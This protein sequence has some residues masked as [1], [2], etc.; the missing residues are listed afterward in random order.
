[1]ALSF[2]SVTWGQLDAELAL[3]L[4]DTNGIRWLVPERRLYLAEALREW[5]ALTQQ[6]VLDWAPTFT[7][8]NPATLPVWQSTGNGVNALAG[9]NPTSPRYQTLTNADVYTLIQYH[10]LEPPSGVGTWIGTSQ[11]SLQDFVNA[12]MRRRDQILQLTDCN[13]GPVQVS[14]IVPN[15]NR[16]QLPD[17]TSRSILDV[18]RVRYLPTSGSP[19]TLYRDDSLAMEYFD[20]QYLQTDE[21]PLTWDVLGSPQQF[22]TFDTL[23]NVPN[24]LDVLAVLSGGNLNPSDTSP[25]LIPDDFFWV[26][27]YG[28]MADLLVK[29][30]ESRD[31]LRAQY[32][33]KRFQEGIQVM[34][35]LPWL[36]QARINNIP[37]DTPS[38]YEADQFDYEWQSNSDAMAQI[39]RG[40]ID[41]FA[42]SPLIPATTPNTS[43]GI[44][45]S[46]VANAVIP[47]ADD[48]FV[49][50]SREILD[51]ILDEAEHLA[52]FKE[53][54]QEF[55][56]SIAL[57]QR[58]IEM[59]VE[60]NR[61]L[62]ESGIF[63]SDLRRPISKEDEAEPRL[64]LEQK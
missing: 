49:Q 17:S 55:Q 32:C 62:K 28:M 27:K 23:V 54:G 31:L 12:F 6:Y 63:Y 50:V 34:K 57:H 22:L 37:V 61:R 58:F 41:L 35:E 13:V 42:I 2:Q 40:G 18:R 9:N 59:A 30:T 16:I 4:N 48:Q 52:Q 51:V 26:L 25:L 11:F 60:T 36:L 8:P 21:A 33:E 64:A 10:L 20:T 19:V 29:E 44:N 46:L 7:Q 56:E 39:V 45:L 3:R 14:S 53:A 5:N 1:M 15:T 47:T 38:F 24:T 43:V